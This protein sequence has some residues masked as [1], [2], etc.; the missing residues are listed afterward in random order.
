MSDFE[1]WVD[2]E[3]KMRCFCRTCRGRSSLPQPD[4][5]VDR[6][7]TALRAGYARG[8]EDAARVADDAE[9]VEAKGDTYYAQLGDAAAT[10]KAIVAAIRSMQEGGK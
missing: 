3:A 9:T 10:R 7:G 8:L 1:T 4:C 2:S 5:C 6:L